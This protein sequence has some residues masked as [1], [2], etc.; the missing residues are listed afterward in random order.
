MCRIGDF[1]HLR[2]DGD[3]RSILENEL[4]GW[5]RNYLPV[6]KSVLDIG[7]GDG[8]TCQF[9]LNHGAEHVICIE[10]DASRLFQNFGKDDRVTILPFAVDTIK[11][12]CEEGE[13]RMVFETHFPFYLKACKPGRVDGTTAMTNLWKIEPLPLL[14]RAH[15]DT[16]RLLRLLR[17]QA[18]HFA[19][20]VLLH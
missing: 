2:L 16:G 12:D 13:R 9:Y 19:S 5:H 4:D 17:I 20:K 1:E 7:A 10:P 14:G 8:E 15:V 6:G 18:A 3:H 11:S